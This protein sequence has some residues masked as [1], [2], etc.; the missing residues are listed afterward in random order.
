MRVFLTQL[1]I[2]FVLMG[3]SYNMSQGPTVGEFIASV[4]VTFLSIVVIICC[5]QALKGWKP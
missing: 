2:F 4:F 1:S 5:S 3:Q